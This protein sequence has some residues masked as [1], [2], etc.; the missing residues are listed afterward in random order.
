MTTQRRSNEGTRD[1]D[2]HSFA[3]LSLADV[4]DARDAYH[5]H[6]VRQRHVVATAVGRYLVRVEE[7]PDADRPLSLADRLELP[8]GQR[9]PRTL[10]NSTVRPWSWPCVL[11]FVDEWM[12]AQEIHE[13]PDQMVPRR[14]Y[15]PDGRM[16]PTCVVYAPPMPM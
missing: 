6:L 13:A 15:L 10:Q 2:A 14:L 9:P 11:V 8:P 7:E 4:L 16:V 1:P 5:V 3:G 12:D